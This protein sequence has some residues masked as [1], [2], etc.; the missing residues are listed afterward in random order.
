VAVVIVAAR[1]AHLVG[2]R[3]TEYHG[4]LANEDPRYPDRCQGAEV[5]CH[6]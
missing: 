2:S 1:T 3:L 6:K 5:G 4:Y